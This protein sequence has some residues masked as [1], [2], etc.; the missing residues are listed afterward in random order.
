M[1]VSSSGKLGVLKTLTVTQRAFASACSVKSSIKLAPIRFICQFYLLSPF[2]LLIKAIDLQKPASAIKARRTKDGGRGRR[3]K[4]K[5][6][7]SE[8]G[9]QKDFSYVC[10]Y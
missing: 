10:Q 5:K 7:F 3:K 1:K 2:V 4:K 6:S 9:E 8:G